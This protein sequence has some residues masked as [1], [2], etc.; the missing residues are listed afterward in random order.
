MKRGSSKHG[1]AALLCFTMVT[2]A[3]CSSSKSENASN[4]SA[5]TD[6][7]GGGKVKIEY[8]QM[9]A[10][11][12]EVVN[13]LIKK[14][15]ESNPNIVVEQNNVPN[16]ENVWT[17]RLST[18]DA[19]AAFTH[20]PHN[21]VFQKM[22][23]EGRIVDLTNDPLMANVQPAIAD[24]S[25]IDGKNYLVPVGVATLG[26]YYNTEL[27]EKHQIKPPATYGELIQ[28]AE[29]LKAAGVTPFAFHDKD[30]NGIRQEVVFKMGQQLP[31]IEKFLDEVMKGKAH[32]TDNAQFK[33]FAQSLLDMRKYGQ[34]DNL[35]TAYND[36]LREFA[37]GKVA[38]WF[39]GIW[40]IKDIKE[41]N[42]NLK[43]AMFPLPTENAADLK[44]QV[45]VDTAI[46]IP[47]GGKNQAEARKFIEFMTSKES[48]ETYLQIG[49]YPSGIKDVKSGR[50]E[51]RSLTQL[52]ND[53][54]VYPTIERLWPPGMNGEVGKATQE[55]LANGDV[56]KYLQTLDTIFF[57]KFN[58]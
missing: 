27:F 7:A 32:I 8:F 55:M 53:G 56:D 24:L 4:P 21:A 9:K 12:V 45:S 49:G 54:K 25:K 10:D 50:E 46:G 36:A 19:P 23:K 31:D 40:A 33:P 28:A 38:M 26:M 30:W 17:M 1:I 16:P 39:T 44:T 6:S 34:K 58:E 57:N 18:N 47:M 37:N 29:K 35:G 48:V 2:A 5:A 13:G 14:F 11:A 42:P 15:E 3:A 51:I 20:Y 43:F 41:S 52:I 22:A